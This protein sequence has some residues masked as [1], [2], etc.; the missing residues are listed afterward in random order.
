MPFFTIEE[1]VST[2]YVYKD[3]TPVLIVELDQNETLSDKV[4]K[5]IGMYTKA[6][7]FRKTTK[8]P[9]EITC[10]ITAFEKFR[11]L[12]Y[13]SFECVVNWHNG[14]EHMFD[15]CNHLELLQ[16]CGKSNT[17]EVQATMR[18]STI[19]YLLL[20]GH[21]IVNGFDN[22]ADNVEKYG[23]KVIRYY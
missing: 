1:E 12:K 9:L 18:F 20:N 5:M 13:I 16:V 15:S 22:V 17:Y 6:L 7:K 21:G 4:I 3:M 11:L 2:T 23:G 19:K 14:L 8:E 10:S